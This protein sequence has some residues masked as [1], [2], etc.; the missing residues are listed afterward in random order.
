MKKG[1]PFSETYL[2]QLR[3]KVGS[4]LLMVP[5]VRIVVENDSSEILLQRRRDI[6]IWGLPGGGCEEG[7][8]VEF[9]F[10]RELREE[11]GL[12]ATEYRAFGI[13][14]HPEIETFT[15]PNGHVIHSYAVLFH[16]TKWTGEPDL[17]NDESQALRFFAPGE[18][19]EML[20][21]ER[22]SLELFFAYRAKRVFQ[23]A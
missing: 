10:A 11:T 18:L 8:S 12:V 14:S 4:R 17:S 7:E 5:G 21:N 1:K 9:A 23:L 16:V 13:S 15:Y 20:P 2:G 19:P 22:Q 6:A 3:E